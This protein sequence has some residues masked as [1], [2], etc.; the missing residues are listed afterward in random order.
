MWLKLRHAE[1]PQQAHLLTSKK[2]GGN[3][4]DENRDSDT[5]M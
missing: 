3:D 2:A 1:L 4:N 5:R